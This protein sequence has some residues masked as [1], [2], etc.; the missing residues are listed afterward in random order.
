MRVMHEVVKNGKLFPHWLGDFLLR[1]LKMFG[2]AAREL[3][4]LGAGIAFGPLC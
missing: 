1:S 3:V 4:L 2:P